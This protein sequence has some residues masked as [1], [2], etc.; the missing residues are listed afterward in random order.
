MGH[1]YR[2][3]KEM[4]KALDCYEKAL[5]IDPNNNMA[6]HFWAKTCEKLK[7]NKPK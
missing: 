1:V 3:K 6:R 7:D 4:H 5:Q 2:L